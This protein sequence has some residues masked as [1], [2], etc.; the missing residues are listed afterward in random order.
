[1]I[2]FALKTFKVHLVWCIFTFHFV[3]ED[4]TCINALCDIIR[5]DADAPIFQRLGLN[6]GKACRFKEEFGKILPKQ[7]VPS[8]VVKTFV[9]PTMTD[10]ASFSPELRR[11]YLSKYVQF[12]QFNTL[13]I[14]NIVLIH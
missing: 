3:D 5:K 11:L 1:M 13:I 6:Y 10:M 2:N 8:P 12:N 7:K 4:I 9:K 14:F